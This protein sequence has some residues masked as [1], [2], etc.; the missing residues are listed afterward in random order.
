MSF[1][2][3]LRDALRLATWRPPLDASAV[4][5]PAAIIGIG[6]T[7]LAI[8]AGADWA[9]A[10]EKAY[11]VMYGM[12][13][14]LAMLAMGLVVVAWFARGDRTGA[15]LRNLTLVAAT[16][17]ALSVVVSVA[18]Q[19]LAGAVAAASWRWALGAFAFALPLSLTVFG[20][21]GARQA[22]KTFQAVRRPALRGV[23]FAACFW[24]VE[25]AMPNWPMIVGDGF[26]RSLANYWELAAQYRR[27][28]A[29]PARKK[30]RDEA[31]ERQAMIEA[32]QPSRLDAAL[33]KLKP[34]SPEMRNVYVVGVA[35]WSEQDVF[36]REIQQSLEILKDRTGAAGRAIALVN[37]PSG[38]D[39]PI[40]N[41]QN[42]A[43]VLRGVAAHMDLEQ[44]VL[45]LTMTSHGAPS[46]FALEFDSMVERML[47]PQI[48][49]R[50]LDTAGFKNRIIVVSSCYSG[51]FVPALA[52][53]QTMIITA[54]SA[55]RT[56]FGCANDRSWTYFGEAFFEH[57]L[58][59]ETSLAAAFSKAK[60]LIAKWEKE[61]NLTPSEPQIFIGPE[62][63]RRFA[64]LIGAQTTTQAWVLSPAPAPSAP[65]P[66]RTSGN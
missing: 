33:A 57:G 52:D 48:L 31:E 55:T 29:E 12:N 47:Q 28:A 39:A 43:Y 18:V 46:G 59:E 19:S 56:S 27:A 3:H 53:A 41:I 11:F 24:T 25:A 5:S 4:L 32:A 61:Q 40:A 44:D 2:S 42:L 36:L 38:A 37:N 63:Q 66:D 58:R 6:A 35:G 8:D 23:A 50:M 49:K 22:F 62:L 17:C 51:Q 30:A 10:G 7:L 21:G 60:G 26:N 64:S 54:A 34:R 15:T 20:A 16:G 65:A 9:T 1:G 45:I 13:A 14:K